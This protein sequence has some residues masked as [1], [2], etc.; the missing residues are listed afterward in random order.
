M[1]IRDIRKATGELTQLPIIV[2]N[3]H[4]H[5]DHVGGNWQFDTSYS[6]DTDFSRQNGK[7][8]VADAQAEIAPGEICGQL[9]TGF[10]P[11]SYT[12]P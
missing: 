9:P 8:N 3:S 6:M 1:G 4:T 12:R 11:K 10:D 7:G 2:L 5:D